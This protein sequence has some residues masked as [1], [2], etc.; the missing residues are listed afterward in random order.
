MQNGLYGVHFITPLG[1]GAG[2][3]VLRD[4]KVQGGDAGIYYDGTY[5]IEGDKFSANL[6]TDRHTP[7]PGV[8]SVFGVDKVDIILKGQFVGTVATVEGTSPQA[9][10]LTF[11]ATLKKLAD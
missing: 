9:P 11:Q 6:R 7:I 3:V 1:V 10:G 5:S 4:G 2:V 8:V